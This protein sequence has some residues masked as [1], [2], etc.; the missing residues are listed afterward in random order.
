MLQKKNVTHKIRSVTKLMMGFHCCGVHRN[1]VFGNI[2][3][4]LS[5]I[6]KK[7]IGM[8]KFT[9]NGHIYVQKGAFCFIVLIRPNP[10]VTRR[11]TENVKFTHR[12]RNCT[13]NIFQNTIEAL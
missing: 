2:L 7:H 8:K 4:I 10:K 3:Q 6:K 1:I 13:Q 11:T 12:L 5:R 9:E